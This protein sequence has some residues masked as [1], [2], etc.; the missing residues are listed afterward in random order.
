MLLRTPKVCG[1]EIMLFDADL[2]AGDNIAVLKKIIIKHTAHPEP[3]V[4]IP[5]VPL[6]QISAPGRFVNFH[7]ERGGR[8]GFKL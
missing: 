1:D 4:M 8:Y 5:S 2:L 3:G 7:L 6:G